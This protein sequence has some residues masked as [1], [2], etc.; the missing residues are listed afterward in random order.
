[1]KVLVLGVLAGC[2][3][4]SAPPPQQ[5]PPSDPTPAPDAAT[6]RV[7]TPP[8]AAPPSE[9]ERLATAEEALRG[10]GVTLYRPLHKDNRVF[11]PSDGY[12]APIALTAD[13]YAYSGLKDEHLV[14]GREPGWEIVYEAK[15]Y[16]AYEGGQ[17]IE[18]D[19]GHVVAFVPSY[20]DPGWLPQYRIVELDAAGAIV[21]EL[22][23]P[24][25]KFKNSPQIH[26]GRL[27]ADGSLALRGH[28]YQGKPGKTDRPSLQ[29]TATITADGKLTDEQIGGAIDW[30]TDDW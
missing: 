21:W 29:W 16:A 18:D 7:V 6:V 2:V 12:L 17:V 9:A 24:R 3:V 4:Q 23:L 28:T 11:Y 27:A 8:D 14:I 19:E 22:K 1:M 10:R 5:P 25:D 26:L 30:K 15:G 20:P 13:G